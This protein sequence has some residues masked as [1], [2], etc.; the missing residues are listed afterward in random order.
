MCD[1][2]WARVVTPTSGMPF[3]PTSCAA[4]SPATAGGALLTFATTPPTRDDR[5]AHTV[6]MRALTSAILLLVV[7]ACAPSAAPT[8]PSPP[9]DPPSIVW[10]WPATPLRIIAPFAEP[11]HAYAAGHRGVDLAAT[12]G[13]SVLA[14][15]DGVVAFSGSVAGRG[16]LTIDH[17]DG[18]VTTL[19]PVS[20]AAP[21]GTS[22][23]RGSGV[24]IVG[25]G[26]HADGTLH[27]G[28]RRYDRY[29]DPAALIGSVPPA[30]L[31]PCC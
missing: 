27:F 11:A 19:E 9:I 17:G 30:V 29:V 22:V 28:V 24:A 4:F 7:L 1:L 13:Q 25:S 10:R 23:S 21:A 6:R 12:P 16:V 31:L 5:A 20:G 8:A 2:E 15:A 3:Q 26:G 14:P 18:W